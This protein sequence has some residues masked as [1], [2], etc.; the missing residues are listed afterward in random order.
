V[1]ISVLAD[2]LIGK[3]KDVLLLCAGWKN[4]V[5]MEDTMFA[6]AVAS[7][8]GEH[9]SINCDSSRIAE[10]LYKKARK[11]LYEFMKSNDASHYHRLTNFGLEKDIRHCLTPDLANILP[12]YVNGKLV[13]QKR[14]TV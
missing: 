3:K 2:Y 6:G 4:R 14:P 8:V 5:N 12:E 1:N 11:D 7:V 9:F 10:T 13:V